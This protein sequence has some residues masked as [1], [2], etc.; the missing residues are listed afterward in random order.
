MT[1]NNR[2]KGAVRCERSAREGKRE[3]KREGTM[4]GEGDARCVGKEIVRG[5]VREG[6]IGSMREVRGEV[7]AELFDFSDLNIINISV[8]FLFYKRD[9]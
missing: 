7:S 9:D 8:L 6:E 5:G 1:G 3:R 2:E 4:A